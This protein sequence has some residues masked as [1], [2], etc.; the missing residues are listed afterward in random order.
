[1]REQERSPQ[2]K[3]GRASVQPGHGNASAAEIEKYVKG[4]DFPCSKDELIRHARDNDAP[5]E[6]L[7]AMEDF[8]EQEYDSAIDVA[9]GVSEVKH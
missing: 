5:D 7:N 8:P 4:I 3:A 1:M 2:H 6:V 9:R